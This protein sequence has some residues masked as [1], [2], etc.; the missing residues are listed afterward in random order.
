MVPMP[1]NS[2]IARDLPVSF[3]GSPARTAATIAASPSAE[4]CRNAPGGGSTAWPAKRIDGVFQQGRDLW[5]CVA[6]RPGDAADAMGRGKGGEF[7]AIGGRQRPVCPDEQVRPGSGEVSGRSRRCGARPP[8]RSTLLVKVPPART[9]QGAARGIRACPR[10]RV[11]VAGASPVASRL[12][13]AWPPDPCGAEH[14]VGCGS[15]PILKD[16]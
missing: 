16:R 11:R 2:S 15:G 4:A 14:W 9:G 6:Q 5:L 7:G 13:C 1:A 3:A 10:R 8:D 12:R